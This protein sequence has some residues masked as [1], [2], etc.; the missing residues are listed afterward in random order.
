MGS[1]ICYKSHDLVSGFQSIVG[2]IG[3]RGQTSHAVSD[4]IDLFRPRGIEGPNKA[5]NLICLVQDSGS[6][7]ISPL[8]SQGILYKVVCFA[9]SECC[10]VKACPWNKI[11]GLRWK[12]SGVLAR[13]I[14][15]CPSVLPM[16]I[17]GKKVPS[18]F[19]VFRTIR[20]SGQ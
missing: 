1:S 20:V 7:K 16:K 9:V 8:P 10:R 5:L 14:L 2:Y 18:F 11:L 4:D 13:E 19:P 3:T 15:Q 6:P 17:I 12:F